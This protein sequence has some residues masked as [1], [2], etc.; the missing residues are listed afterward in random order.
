MKNS[1]PVGMPPLDS[2]HHVV[3]N[4][5]LNEADIALESHLARVAQGD[6][7]YCT[8]LLELLE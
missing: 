4:L 1:L 7:A 6:I 5:N 2:L 8:S 3:C